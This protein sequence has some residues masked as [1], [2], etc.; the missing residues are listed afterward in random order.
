VQHAI[1]KPST[2]PTYSSGSGG[3]IIVIVIEPDFVSGDFSV[4]T[5]G[6]SPTTSSPK[7]IATSEDQ[8]AKFFHN[9]AAF[10]TKTP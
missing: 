7:I 5:V 4:A 2:S 9:S 8:E 3:V 6:E 1:P 10:T